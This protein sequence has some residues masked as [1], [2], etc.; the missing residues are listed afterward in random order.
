MVRTSTT[1]PSDYEHVFANTQTVGNVCV[2]GLTTD[3]HMTGDQYLTSLTTYFIG[4]VL[5][6]IPHNIILKR[7][8]P[9]AWLPTLT[10]LWGTVATLIGVTQN[11]TGFLVVRFF[12]GM[13]ES[14]LFP[15]VVFYLSMWYKRNERTFRVALFFSAASLAGAFGGVLAWGIAHMDGVGSY[16]GWRWIFIQ[17]RFCT[18]APCTTKYS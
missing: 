12:L 15:G 10:L 7:T 14:G 2:E 16:A 4:Y 17:V 6:E 3:L 9:R 11:T 13:A 18:T 5:F 8:S 1:N